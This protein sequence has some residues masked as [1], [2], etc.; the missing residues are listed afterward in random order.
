[1]STPQGNNTRYRAAGR[2]RRLTTRSARLMLGGALGVVAAGGLSACTGIT[3]AFDVDGS[4]DAETVTYDFDSFDRVEI[5]SAFESTITIQSGDPSVEVTMDDNLFEDLDIEVSDGWLRIRMD[6]G[7]YDHKV[8]PEVVITMPSLVE[9][10]V[11]G[12]TETE[13]IGLSEPSFEVDS[14]G[15]ADLKLFGAMGSLR[16][17]ASGASNIEG[18]GSATDITLDTS[19]AAGVDLDDVSAETVQVDM[20]GASN[21][22]LGEVSEV[23]GDLSGASSLEVPDGT[24]VSVSTSGAASVERD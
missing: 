1:M 21:A 17:D 2:H 6:D 7:T 11:G 4:G 13:V 3:I 9:L 10:D 12:A 23:S 8:D 19:G 24:T 18:D 14:S 15:A 20:S 22:E 5:G 16:I